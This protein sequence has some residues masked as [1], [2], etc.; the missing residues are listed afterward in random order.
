MQTVRNRILELLKQDGQ[1]S[2]GALAERL[3]MA[4]ISVRY[5]LDILLSDNLIT[6]TKAKDAER[7]VVHRR[8]TH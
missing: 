6:V 3:D 4:P 7:S 5:H 1:A 8:S 2:V